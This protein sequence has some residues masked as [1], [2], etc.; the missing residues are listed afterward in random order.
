MSDQ[1]TYLLDGVRET[2][3][4]VYERSWWRI[5]HALSFMVGGALFIVGTVLLF[6]PTSTY[7]DAPFQ[8]ALLYVIGSCGFLCVDVMEFFTFHE[9]PLRGNILMSAVGSTFYV[10][11][12][13]GF[14]PHIYTE[15]SVYGIYGFILGS[16]I[17][18]TSQTWKTIRLAGEEVPQ[19][20]NDYGKKKPTIWVYS[21]RTLFSSKDIFT[22]AGVEASAG[23][24]AWSF[25][26]GTWLLSIHE[27]SSEWYRIVLYIWVFGSVAFTT[28]AFFL[29]YRHFVMKVT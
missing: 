10:I 17:I 18:G 23:I 24:G 2:E 21:V 5:L 4:A 28:G 27:N 11:G 25:F 16:V 8:S 3:V 12:S 14:L 29:A 22:A 20:G 7:P 1:S 13:A 6:L 9:C 15:T 26:V 19:L